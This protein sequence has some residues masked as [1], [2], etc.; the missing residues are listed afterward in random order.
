M[1]K[2][3]KIKLNLIRR[4]MQMATDSINNAIVITLKWINNVPCSHMAIDEVVAATYA[5]KR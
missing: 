3:L 5:S 4:S 2:L 1:R